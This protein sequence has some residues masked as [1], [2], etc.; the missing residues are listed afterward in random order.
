M[1]IILDDLKIKVDIPMLLNYDNK[2][3]MSITHN[4]VQY[5]R[6]KHIEI[7]NTSLKIILTK[8]L[9]LQPISQQDFS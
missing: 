1:K 2:L 7:D 8:I 5:N 4:P 9:W 6:I 3:A